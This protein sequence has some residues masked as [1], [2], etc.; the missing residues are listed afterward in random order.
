MSQVRGVEVVGP[1]V[2]ER[3]RGLGRMAGDFRSPW[4]STAVPLRYELDVSAAAQN[5]GV[6]GGCTVDG[7]ALRGKLADRV[8][9]LIFGVDHL[10][11]G[12]A[13]RHLGVRTRLAVAARAPRPRS[14]MRLVPAAASRSRLG[15]RNRL[16]RVRQ[17]RIIGPKAR[18]YGRPRATERSRGSGN[19]PKACGASQPMRLQRV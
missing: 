14:P 16:A 8:A 17:P 7:E 2:G 12:R 4:K 1:S 10:T 15:R 5:D 3:V 19:A 6:T 18:P 9:E 13:Q 11:G